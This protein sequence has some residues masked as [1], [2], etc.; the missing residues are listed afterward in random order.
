MVAL[1]REQL[2]EMRQQRDHWQTEAADWKR[3]AQNLLPPPHQREA[4]DRFAKAEEAS[5]SPRRFR[6]RRLL[7]LLG[8]RSFAPCSTTWC[9]CRRPAC[10][11]EFNNREIETP[12]R[13]MWHAVTVIRRAPRASAG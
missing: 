7:R 3:Q 6:S 10:E 13:G 2:A 12:A 8:Q 1:L 5:R 9:I 4:L 11:T